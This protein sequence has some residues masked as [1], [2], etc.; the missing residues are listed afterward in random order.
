MQRKL[1]QLLPCDFHLSVKGNEI[2]L[3]IPEYFKGK[4]IGKGGTAISNLEKEI[5][6]AIH[7]R[8]FNELPLLDVKVDLA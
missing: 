2:D 1:Q 7:V 5:G 6:L 3:Y 8:T 4:I